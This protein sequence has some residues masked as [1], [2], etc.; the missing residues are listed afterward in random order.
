VPAAEGIHLAAQL[1]VHPKTDWTDADYP[2]RTENGPG[3]H[4]TTAMG[5][6]FTNHYQPNAADRR[7]PRASILFTEVPSDLAPAVIGVGEYDILRDEVEAY[8]KH[9]ADAGVDVA[10][11]RA[12]GL[13]H[14]CFGMR[15]ASAAAA[16]AVDNLIADLRSAPAPHVELATARTHARI[17]DGTE[18]E[19]PTVCS[20]IL[21][22]RPAMR[23]GLT[24]KGT[25]ENVVLEPPR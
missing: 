14:G 10:Y 4:L 12:D 1:L 16:E 9:L 19:R 24:A 5:D 7:D 8:A 3:Y 6:W 11:H 20:P 21:A 25:A 17:A 18:R 23:L 22:E 15:L 13:M 2:S